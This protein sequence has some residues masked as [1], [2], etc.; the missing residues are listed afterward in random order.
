V[1]ARL[2]LGFLVV[3]ACT[4]HA[5]TLMVMNNSDGGV[6]SL[7]ATLASAAMG[8]TINFSADMTIT[9]ASTLTL[10]QNVTI[11]GSGHAV[12]VDG[13]HLVRVLVVNSGV[14]AQLS[15]LTIRNGYD[16]SGVG[17]GGILNDGVLA[18]A[19]T[20]LSGNGAVGIDGANG[21]AGTNSSSALAGG[22]GGPGGSGGF[23]YGGG[24]YNRGTLTLTHSTVSGNS[25]T[26]GAGG[27][28]G[29]G[30]TGGAGFSG[31][32]VGTDGWPGGDGGAGGAGGVSDGGGI[33]NGG[34][35]TLINS[36]LS[37]NS[38]VGGLGGNGG[39]GGSGG[40]GGIGIAGN[41]AAG[42]SGARGIGGAG[43]SSFGAGIFNAGTLAQT[44]GTLSGN[45]VTA[46]N[47]GS[48]SISGASGNA[49][50]GGIFN[51]AVGTTTLTNSTLSGN[52]A[53]SLGGG[54]AGTGVLN[55]GAAVTSVNTIIGDGCSG[56]M[57]DGG[58]N[59]DTGATCGF[60]NGVNGSQTNV[61]AA[62]LNLGPL[63]NYGGPTQTML[64]GPGSVAIDAIACTK[65]PATDQRD[66]TRPQGTLCDIGAVEVQKTVQTITF[67][68]PVSQ[69][70]ATGSI[71]VNPTASSGLPV[72]LVSNSIAVCTVSGTG[73]FTIALLSAGNCSLTAAQGG[74]GNYAAATPVNASFVVGKNTVSVAITG[75]NPSAAKVGQS[76][77]VGVS[78][79]GISAPVSTGI[80][81][82]G[83][84]VNGSANAMPAALPQPTGSV[85][86]TDITGTLV[87]CPASLAG[88]VGSCAITINT[89]GNNTIQAIY[90]GDANYAA[91]AQP[92]IVTLVAAAPDP[93]VPAPLLERW[94]LLLLTSLIGLLAFARVRARA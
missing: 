41:G 14:G 83:Q 33:Y 81:A 4:A 24:I 49:G 30:G 7:R 13:N 12:V 6:G 91:S 92:A 9:L 46:G 43:A 45:G 85:T 74:N 10:S 5:A 58:G 48:G 17:G 62:A 60:T 51:S 76:V 27:A 56:T 55:A 36:T 8:D 65:A 3:G 75:V 32:M 29:T 40:P 94:A 90:N 34:T 53:S 64:P 18:L 2:A 93:I 26:G 77:T 84:M 35:L 39:A 16:D 73:P 87:S 63:A 78:V 38:T 66:V 67:A 61:V 31:S 22:N 80:V 50:G 54:A 44:N 1:L 79:T 72:T 15:H 19:Y 52:S 28:G 11:D 57:M 23:A 42:P 47:G 20:T 69:V 21:V 82:H 59:I 86:I 68:T 71:S 37:G 89:A 88:G 70:L 25:A